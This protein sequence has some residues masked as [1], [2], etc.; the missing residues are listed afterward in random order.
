MTDKEI[1]EDAIKNEPDVKQWYVLK[2]NMSNGAYN[3]EIVIKTHE[4]AL[5]EFN[6]TFPRDE[7]ERIELM[8]TPDDG[9]N[10]VAF[11]KTLKEG[12]YIVETWSQYCK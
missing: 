5:V 6:Q 4:E 7:N 2:Y 9:D 8:F 12:H 11:V 10:I 3:N 1:L